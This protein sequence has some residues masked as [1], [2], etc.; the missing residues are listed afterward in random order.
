[1]EK[2]KHD[3]PLKG[4]RLIYELCRCQHITPE[5]FRIFAVIA[6]Y[7]P[8][9]PSY[10]TIIR[11]A[12][13]MAKA[14]LSR[15]IKELCARRMI[16]YQRGFARGRSNLYVILPTDDWDLTTP[17]CELVLELNRPSRRTS[18]NRDVKQFITKNA[19]GA[20][21]ELLPVRSEPPKPSKGIRYPV[22]PT[23]QYEEDDSSSKYSKKEKE[24]SKVAAM[25]LAY[26]EASRRR[27]GPVQNLIGSR[28]KYWSAIEQAANLAAQHQMPA[29]KWIED[30]A[31]QLALAFGPKAFPWPSQLCG[32]S[33]AMHFGNR[34]MAS[35]EVPGAKGFQ[36]AKHN[37][38]VPLN[39]DLE[40]QRIRK[41]I[42]LDTHSDE[43][44]VY[45]RV[46]QIQRQGY[47]SPWLAE[48]ERKLRERVPPATR[49]TQ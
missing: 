14:T 7:N 1:M 23:N 28:S 38:D 33:A 39:E 8:S 5:V 36:R 2:I 44:V 30:I 49:P 40:Y 46:R 37:K 13:G 29:A 34:R 11:A 41:R 20:N 48:A 27:G 47:E 21:Q 35:G 43:D 17:S 26:M 3:R 32:D 15:S 10:E 16:S 4:V 24:N 22:K 9:F 42:K 18:T 19:T 12:G 31:I 25:A 45:A 6:S